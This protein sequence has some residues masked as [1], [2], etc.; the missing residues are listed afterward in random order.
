[1]KYIEIKNQQERRL[2]YNEVALMN[3]AKVQDYVLQ[4]YESYDF[5]QRLWIF[6]E[7]MDHALTPIVEQM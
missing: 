7:L 3:M 6:V 1:M 4:I 5:M 2:I